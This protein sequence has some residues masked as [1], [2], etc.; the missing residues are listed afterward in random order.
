MDQ[1]RITMGTTQ[2]PILKVMLRLGADD[3]HAAGAVTQ[4]VIESYARDHGLNLDAAAKLA[5]KHAVAN[6][7]MELRQKGCLAPEARAWRLTP[8]GLSVAKGDVPLPKRPANGSPIRVNSVRKSSPDVAAEDGASVE[9]E[10]PTEA[11]SPPE[12]PVTIPA[13]VR[14]SLPVAPVE[15]VEELAFRI[16]STPRAVSVSATVVQIPMMDV[17]GDKWVTDSIIRGAVAANQSCF[18]SWHPN[19]PECGACALNPWCRNAQATTLSLL[20]ERLHKDEVLEVTKNLHSAV[21]TALNGT[22]PRAHAAFTEGVP[23]RASFDGICALTGQ[24]Y[25]KGDSVILRPGAGVHRADATG[26]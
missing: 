2:V 3:S 7:A 16:D 1:A 23:M 19:H 14:R 26:K 15:S 11:S 17:S 5:A 6:A 8:V 22:T 4:E 10:T 24:S 25:A 20:G 21:G 18:G 12:N 13:P 9:G